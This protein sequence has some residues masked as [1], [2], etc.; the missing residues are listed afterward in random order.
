MS[1]ESKFDNY[2]WTKRGMDPTPGLGLSQATVAMMRA[3]SG[4]ENI[5]GS[6]T[7]LSYP[8]YTATN[9]KNNIKLMILFYS[10]KVLFTGQ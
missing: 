5:L 6:V 10:H 9:I 8:A 2:T 3:I 4:Q 1:N 7:T